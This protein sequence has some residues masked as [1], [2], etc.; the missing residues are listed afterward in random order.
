MGRT[1]FGN[2]LLYD[3]VSHLSV[4]SGDLNEDGLNAYVRI[5]GS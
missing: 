4:V 5:L 1:F 3:P 2:K